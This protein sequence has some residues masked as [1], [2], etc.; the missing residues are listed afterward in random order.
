[1]EVLALQDLAG[2]AVK[3]GERWKC[4][5]RIGN[6]MAARGMVRVLKHD[7]PGDQSRSGMIAGGSNDGTDER[8]DSGGE[9]EPP[10]QEG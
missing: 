1:M 4:D 9:P 8:T 5:P 7:P 6:D 3:K 10:D 2:H